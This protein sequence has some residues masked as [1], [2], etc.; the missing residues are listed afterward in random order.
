[1]KIA[2][3][4][5]LVFFTFSVDLDASGLETTRVACLGDSITAGARVDAKT[6]SYPARLQHLLGD[7]Y[8]V[9]NFGIGG[10]TLIKTGR[11]NIWRNLDTVK[12]FEP[13]FIVISL[14]TNDTVGGSRKNWEQIDRCD[15]DYSELINTLSDL[16]TKPHIVV[17]TPT[18]I[19]LETLGLS[20]ERLANLA[21]RKPRLQ[22]LCERIRRLAKQHADRNT[23]LLELN[24]VLQN[25]PGLLT[26]S[27]GVHPNAEG[28]TAIAQAVAAHIRQQNEPTKKRPNIVLFLVDDMGWQDTSVPFHTEVT[29]LNRR[30]HTPN[31]ERL[32]KAGMR[33]TQAYACSVC[34]PTRV[35]LMTGMNASRHRVTN[36]TLRK[37][38]SN[39]RPH[40]RLDLPKWNVNGISPVP[41]I[42]RTV[43]AK[44]LPAFLSEAGYHTIHVGKAHFG[45]IGTPGSDPLKIGFDRNIAG[46]AAGGPGSFL[47]TQNFSAAWRNGDRVWDVPDLEAYHGKD[48]FLTEAL[49]IE[50]N[51]A[52]DQAVAA[53]KPFFLYMSHYAV[54]VPFAIDSR[55]HQ[56]YFD[57]GLDKTEAMYAAMVEG[58]DKS[59]GDVLANINHHGLS[60]ETIVLFISDNGGLSAHGRGGVAHTHNK[61][62]S[63]GKGSAHEGGV[64]VPMIVSWPRVTRPDSVCQQPVIIEDFFPTILE[65]AGVTEIEQ[66]G[67]VVDGQ[68]F[69]N[70]LRG[71][72]D[73][74]RQLRPLIWH[75][76]NNWGPSGPGIGPSSA[77]R[78]GKWKL[79]H[80]YADQRYELFD[81]ETDLGEHK[82]LANERADVR[83]KLASTLANYLTS[84]NAQL[85]TAR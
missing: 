79:I 58:M 22:Q 16:P 18:A 37:N 5:S 1:M 67:G 81:L 61:P 66:I 23:S 56:K 51:R 63:S 62:L 49:T 46:H 47:G 70:L 30:Y 15:D 50:A 35:S 25:R 48:I 43:H 60:E 13:H 54:H 72:D 64:R 33:F 28:Y 59:L 45:A 53:N 7:A 73:A 40:P 14:G 17:C 29:G 76:P 36:W 41:G 8:E 68:S 75:F 77:I 3:A 2:F 31:M 9:R 34:S 4:I 24:A 83:K 21:E 65:M 10:A 85:P 52:V 74:A 80:Y 26:E 44:C 84:V 55:F 39:D 20:A 11:P 69:T 82:N 78:L 6:E 27:D 19:V 57:A 71:D 12:K 38:A 42:E 32:A